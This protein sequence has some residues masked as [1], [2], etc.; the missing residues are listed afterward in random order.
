MEEKLEMTEDIE[1][2]LLKAKN[3]IEQAIETKDPMHCLG[4]IRQAEITI[5][6]HVVYI[7]AKTETESKNE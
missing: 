4:H 1:Y 2:F 6:S 7:Q 5:R 3:A